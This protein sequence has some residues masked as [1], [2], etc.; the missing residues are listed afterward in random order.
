[1]TGKKV[2]RKRDKWRF[3]P[4]AA[5]YMGVSLR[6]FENIILRGEITVYQRKVGARRRVKLKDLKRL[7]ESWK[8]ESSLTTLDFWFS[9]QAVKDLKE[10]KIAR[11]ILR[12]NGQVYLEAVPEGQL[13]QVARCYKDAVKVYSG[14]NYRLS[15]NGKGV[16]LDFSFCGLGG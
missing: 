3:I 13:C 8:C 9:R 14:N 4:E 16:K 7:E 15:K 1:M 11:D 12:V 6:D 5:D 2:K 10:M